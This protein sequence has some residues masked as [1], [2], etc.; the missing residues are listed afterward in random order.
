MRQTLRKHLLWNPLITSSAFLAA[1]LSAAILAPAAFAAVPT[2]VV[3]TQFA[4]NDPNLAEPQSIAIAPNNTRYVAD[5]INNVVLAYVNDV[6]TPVSTPG[7]TL[8]GPDAVAVDTMGDLFIGDSPS[9]GVG[10]VIEAMATNGVL[11]G[12]VNLVVQGGALM[13][14]FS[15]TVDTNAGSS[16]LNT[17][18]I[19]D[20]VSH[21]LYSVAPGSSTLTPMNISGLPN[22]VNPAALLKDRAGNLFVADFLST[23]YEIPANSSTATTFIASGFLLKGPTGLAQDPQGNLYIAALTAPNGTLSQPIA[24]NIVEIPGP[25]TNYDV[26]NAFRIP[27]TGLTGVSSIGFDSLGHLYIANWKDPVVVEEVIVGGPIGLSSAD[28]GSIGTGVTFNYEVNSPVKVKSF[29]FSSTGDKS[30]EIQDV[31]GGNC[32]TGNYTR[33]SDNG[34]ISASDPLVCQKKFA[35]FPAYPGVRYG[36]VNMV[37]AGNTIVA[38]T[39][40]FFTG[41][42]GASVVYPL[43]VRPGATDIAGPGVTEGVDA[44]AISGLDKRIYVTDGYG[45]EVLY[46][47]GPNTRNKAFT[48]VDTKSVQLYQPYGIALNGAGDLY[49]ADIYAGRIVVVP[50]NQAIAPYFFN[51]GNLLLHPLSI[52]FDTS[53]NMFIGDAGLN[54]GNTAVGTGYLVEVPVGGGAP[55]KVNTSGITLNYPQGLATD[56]YTGDIYIADSGDGFYTGAQVVHIVANG[57][58]ASVVT[59]PGVT[60]PVSIVF[61]AAD[62]YYVL[63][64]IANTITVV[65]PSGAGT[66]Y[67]LPFDNSSLFQ[68]GAMAASPGAQNFTIVNIAGTH[69]DNT[70]TNGYLTY[71]NGKQST[72]NFGRVAKGSQSSAMP[73][74][75]N[76]IGNNVLQLQSPAIT[77]VG[78]TSQF[79]ATT[80][81]CA[82][83]MSLGLGVPCNLG[84]VFMPTTTGGISATYTVHT[85][86]YVPSST[87][88]LKGRGTAH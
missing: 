73:V 34:P 36:A 5:G 67:A 16:T 18:Y 45:A 47:S 41:I 78:D 24:L 74:L 42:A 57:G 77:G 75:V 63:D 28:V 29:T 32:G 19:G 61:D 76:N 85:N 13:D 84:Y 10:R 54:N 25:A 30:T 81:N 4:P 31:P 20:D 68:A 69:P 46:T 23:V 64:Q 9:S 35:A 56:P 39:P 62:D 83:G 3:D 6:S 33:G 49:I 53:G 14:V 7:F 88:V 60:G 66:P 80:N 26:N 1:L 2:V 82:D 65:P 86:G 11:N 58:A 15:L 71:L 27:F 40:V 22:N 79:T 44:I 52:A 87:F 8:V 70:K 38:T 51:P 43:T 50:A 12:T 48:K 59:P 17:L 21:A 72:T 37:S 55:F